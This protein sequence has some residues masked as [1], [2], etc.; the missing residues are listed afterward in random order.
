VVDECCKAGEDLIL[1]LS[2]Y[3]SFRWC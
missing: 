2:H 3:F 1:G